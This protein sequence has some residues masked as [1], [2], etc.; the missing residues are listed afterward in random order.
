MSVPA[1]KEVSVPVLASVGGEE[2]MNDKD[3]GV[4]RE[5]RRNLPGRIGGRIQE[6]GVPKRDGDFTV[7]SL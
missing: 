7:R 1:L 5:M 2:C 4:D 6:S 3:G